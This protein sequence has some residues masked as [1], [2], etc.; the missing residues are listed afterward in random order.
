MKSKSTGFQTWF[1][2]THKY[3]LVRL[4]SYMEH[5]VNRSAFELFESSQHTNI[6]LLQKQ[7]ELENK[8]TQNQDRKAVFVQILDTM[9]RLQSRNLFCNHKY[10][11]FCCK[12][13]LI[14]CR[15]KNYYQQSALNQLDMLYMYFLQKPCLSHKNIN[16]ITNQ[17]PNLLNR[18][19]VS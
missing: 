8:N 1:F 2:L 3:T 13:S 7:Y 18:C 12:Y 11:Y 17:I 5:I 14:Q 6:Y 4:M 9:Y 16:F 10:L 15:S 19:T